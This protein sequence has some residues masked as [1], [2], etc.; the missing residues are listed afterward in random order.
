[1]AGSMRGLLQD[2]RGSGGDEDSF[3]IAQFQG[4]GSYLVVDHGTPQADWG[5]NE[6]M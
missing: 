1:M 2:V 6:A 4:V 3:R 5:L